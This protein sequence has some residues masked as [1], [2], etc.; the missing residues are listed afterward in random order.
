MKLS[1]KTLA[2]TSSKAFLKNRKGSGTSISAF[3]CKIFQ[4]KYFCCYILLPDQISVSGCLYF[5]RYWA[6]CV[7]KLFVHQCDIILFEIKLIYLNKTFFQHDQKVYAK[8]QISWEWEELL[9]WNKKHFSSFHHCGKKT[10]FL[11]EG[12]TF[13]LQIFE[14]FVQT[15][16]KPLNQILCERLYSSNLN[17][18]IT[19]MHGLAVYVKEGL[20]FEPVRISADSYLCFQLALSLIVLPLTITF[21]IFMRG[22]LSYFI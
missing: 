19:N 21:C 17:D 18:S 11:D 10:V 8:I 15:L 16:F 7:L 3:F 6:I 5:V 1:Y 22:F 20:C 14:T 4:E 9:R 2:F 12:A 13:S